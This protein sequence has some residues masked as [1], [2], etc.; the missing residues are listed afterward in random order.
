MSTIKG[1]YYIR[2]D[3]HH[4]YELCYKDKL[5]WTSEDWTP[6]KV[7]ITSRYIPNRRN[8]T[9]LKNLLNTWFEDSSSADRFAGPLGDKYKVKY[10]LIL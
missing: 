9:A 3:I 6:D 7:G 10:I 5:L 4:N 1:F 8:V 2:D